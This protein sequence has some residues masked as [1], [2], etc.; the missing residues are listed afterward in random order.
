MNVCTRCNSSLRPNGIYCSVCGLHKKGGK[1]RIFL[2]KNHKEIKIEIV[3]KIPDELKKNKICKFYDLES[4]SQLKID[5][6]L[7]RLHKEIEGLENTLT[8]M[9][10]HEP[11]HPDKMGFYEERFKVRDQL[12]AIY[13]FLSEVERERIDDFIK[14][15]SLR[16]KYG[17]LPVWRIK[18]LKEKEAS[19]YYHLRNPN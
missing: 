12:D 1:G 19:V 2:T 8:Y 14:N 6:E 11:G 16:I 17:M 15:S 4:L 13:S 18:Q 9:E 3:P 5:S 7:K 10:E